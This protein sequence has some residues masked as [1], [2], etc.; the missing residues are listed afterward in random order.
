MSKSRAS[1][2]QAAYRIVIL[3]A[4]VDCTYIYWSIS[5]THNL[6]ILDNTAVSAS[7]RKSR[8]RCHDSNWKVPID[9]TKQKILPSWPPPENEMRLNLRRDPEDAVWTRL[10]LAKQ[11]YFMLWS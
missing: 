1:N 10:L 11:A 5:W 4:C 9:G 2:E 7:Q 6:L 3:V 8:A